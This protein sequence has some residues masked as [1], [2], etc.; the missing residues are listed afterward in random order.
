MCVLLKYDVMLSVWE[1]IKVLLVS[2]FLVLSLSLIILC[3]VRF[4]YL[5][6]SGVS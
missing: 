1:D 5:N 6:F 4:K 3:E 2:F